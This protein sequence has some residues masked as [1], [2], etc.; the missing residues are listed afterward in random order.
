MKHR[1]IGLSRCVVSFRGAVLIT[2]LLMLA[3]P[4]QAVDLQETAKA[5]VKLYVATQNWDIRQPWSKNRVKK[6][7]CSGF[8]TEKGIMTNAHCV[9][10]ATYIQLEVPG[11]PDKIEAERVAVNHQV[12]LALI[13]AKDPDELPDDIRIIG[14]DSPLPREREKVVTVGYPVGGRQVSFTEGVV[15]RMDIMTYA[16]S[17]LHNLLVQTDAAINSGNSGGPVF[18]D[19]SGACLGVATQRRSGSMGYFIPVPVIQQFLTDLEDGD[20]NG[21]PYLGAFVQQLENP[22]LR[23]YLGMKDGQSGVRVTK[24]A[25]DGSAGGAFKVNDVIMRVDGMQVFNDGR[26]PFREYSKIGLGYAVT[27]HQVGDTLSFTLLR[28]GKETKVDL[29]LSERDFKV[30][31]SMPEYDTRPR[32]YVL[33]GFLF[34]PVEPRYFGKNVPFSIQKYGSATRG[35]QHGLEELVVISDIYE[36]DLNKG[37]DGAHTNFRVVEVNDR[38]ISRLDDLIKAFE[39]HEGTHH[40]IRLENLQTIVLERDRVRNEERAI[41]NRYNIR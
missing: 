27:S 14:F 13:R 4:A 21:V 19:V 35:D 20:V 11:L 5:V 15:S 23:E 2:L 7:I 24:V 8:F 22:M 16:H 9:T 12:D 38:R 6:R 25:R 30:I 10:D 31:P 36:A 34:R 18:S 26:I 1:V 29:V 41:R 37:Y 33:G 39:E 40:V 3:A 28:D 32:Y 17:S